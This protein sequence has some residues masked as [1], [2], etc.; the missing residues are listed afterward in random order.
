MNKSLNVSLACLLSLLIAGKMSPAKADA[1]D[2]ALEGALWG[3]I[4]GGGEGAATGALIG[5]AVGAADEDQRRREYEHRSRMRYEQERA[6]LERRRYEDERRMREERERSHA[7]EMERIRAQQQPP[8]SAAPSR[9]VPTA[10]VAPSRSAS[11]GTNLVAEIQRSLTVLGYKPGP[12]DGNLGQNTTEAI[13]SY[14]QD[15]GLL[16]T[17]TP[18]EELL[19]HMRQQGG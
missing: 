4:I 16:T 6:D 8:A 18:S 9:A 1:W 17:G 15:K 7:L 13:K 3:G 11:A 12:V 19:I 14:Q 10:S 2:G 5:G